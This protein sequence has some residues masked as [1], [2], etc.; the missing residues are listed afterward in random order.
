MTEMNKIGTHIRNCSIAFLLSV[1]A[2]A[3]C[4]DDLSGEIA[5]ENNHSVPPI[6]GD[7]GRLSHSA[8]TVDSFILSWIPAS[9]DRTPAPDLR[10][11]A[12]I[13]EED[14]LASFDSV[15]E[16]ISSK[17]AVEITAGWTLNI[18]SVTVSSLTPGAVYYCNVFV[19]DRDGCIS[20]YRPLKVSM[21]SDGSP[22]PG[23]GGAVSAQWNS[24]SVALSWALSSDA[25]T[26]Q[27][28]LL[29]KVFRTSA[30]P[31]DGSASVVSWG[32]SAAVELTTGWS[33]SISS[34]SVLNLSAD[35]LYWFNV[36]VKDFR[37]NISAY[38]P[39]SFQTPSSVPVLSNTI[40]E[41]TTIDSNKYLS[42]TKATD[43][44]SSGSVSYR[45]FA[46]LHSSSLSAL[47]SSPVAISTVVLASETLNSEKVYEL[48]SGW[49]LDLGSVV[50]PVLKA[51]VGTAANSTGV[52]AY[53]AVFA[54]S[55]EGDVSSYEVLPLVYS[56]GT[57]TVSQ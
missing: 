47:P 12:V 41:L 57:W 56:G 34:I 31:S 7:Q 35:S 38:T 49:T 3:S 9:D 37:G 2:F 33:E 1:F 4:G 39:V 24:G 27:E 28:K 18:S 44:Y 53:F 54:R 6:A 25:E 17:R 36:F 26:P 23:G 55:I 40:L 11:R 13:S 20:P 14:I 19:L 8:M 30:N 46:S 29:Y 15:D 5:K 48:T 32:N 52:T 43:A 51:Y 22:V 10:Y 21:Q 42:W 16:Y 50:L 45:V